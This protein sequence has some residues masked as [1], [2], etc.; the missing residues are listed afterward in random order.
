MEDNHASAGLEA[1]TQQKRLPRFGRRF[2]L[3]LAIA[4][5]L[6]CGLAWYFLYF[7]KTPAYSLQ[8]IEKAVKTHDAQTFQKRVDLDSVLSRT[9]DDFMEIAIALAMKSDPSLT[10]ET[11]PYALG[12]LQ[13]IKAPITAFLKDTATRY[14]ETGEWQTEELAEKL[15][16]VDAQ[17]LAEGSGLKNYSFRKLAYIRETGKTAIAGV[18]VYDE[19]TARE[20]T[21]DLQLRELA[22]GSWQIAGIANFKDCLT[23]MLAAKK[24]VIRQYLDDTRPLIAQRDAQLDAIR[25]KLRNAASVEEKTALYREAAAL[26]QQSSEQFRTAATPAAASLF[27]ILQQRKAKLQAQYYEQRAAQP[28]RLSAQQHKL[29]AQ[30]AALQRQLE[31]FQRMLADEE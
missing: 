16:G 21:F 23:E 27:S 22:D 3:P 25:Q 19:E 13:M 28:N 9:Y 4:C 18:T 10:P 26:C 30:I 8:E 29:T 24:T 6:L 20:F 1:N 7:I 5:L 14:V 17:Q 12:L 2:F 11:K 15:P 31:Q